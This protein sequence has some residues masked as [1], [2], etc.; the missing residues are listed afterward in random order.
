MHLGFVRC[1]Q[2]RE[3]RQLDRSSCCGD[4]VRCGDDVVLKGDAFRVVDSTSLPR[5]RLLSAGT[6]GWDESGHVHERSIPRNQQSVTAEVIEWVVG[7]YP[8]RSVR[9]SPSR[10]EPRQVHHTVTADMGDSSISA[11][12]VLPW[13]MARA[14]TM[15]SLTSHELGRGPSNGGP[16][17]RTA[18]RPILSARV[19]DA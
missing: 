11:T 5:Y 15:V 4:S 8:S 3:R 9:W 12:T 13:T 14:A 19:V 16:W 7:G 10:P 1:H 2:S 18:D 6:I 17:N